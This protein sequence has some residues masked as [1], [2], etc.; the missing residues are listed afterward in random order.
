MMMMQ[1][2]KLCMPLF[3][4]WFLGCPNQWGWCPVCVFNCQPESPIIVVAIV[5]SREVYW[6]SSQSTFDL[7]F[8]SSRI[9]LCITVS[10]VLHPLK[11]SFGRRRRVYKRDLYSLSF[12]FRFFLIP[13]LLLSSS[14]VSFSSSVS[15]LPSLNHSWNEERL[16]LLLVLLLLSRVLR[17]FFFS[18]FF[19]VSRLLLSFSCLLRNRLELIVEFLLL[20]LHLI[21][22]QTTRDEQEKKTLMSVMIVSSSFKT[23]KQEE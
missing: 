18:C 7:G 19:W 14:G 1:S 3:V 12:A 2:H 21:H 11:D 10:L 8:D 4:L 17:G 9:S 16:L 23:D 20:L 6:Q 15:E 22:W 5:S 13:C